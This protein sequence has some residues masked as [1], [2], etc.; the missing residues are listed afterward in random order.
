VTEMMK[1]AVA[2]ETGLAIHQVSRPEPARE[3]VLV[4]VLA[5]GMNRADLNAAKGAGIT[6]RDSWGK[7]IGMEWAG[8]VVAVGDTVTTFKPG[9][10][11]MC[12]GTGGYAEYAVA[13]FGRTISLTDSKLTIEQAAAL[14]LA[15]MTAHDAVVTNGRVRSVDT[16]LVQGASS[17]VGLASMQIAKN[18]GAR[19]VIGTSTS[20]T[21]STRLREFGADVVVDPSD[22]GWSDQ[23]LK[24]T[25]GQGANVIVDMVSGA[26]VNGSMKAAAVRGRMVNVGRLGG[27]RVDFDLDLHSLKRL[28]YIG[29]TFRTRSISEVREIVRAMHADLWETIV[30]GKIRLPIDRCFALDDAIAA[31]AHM[32]S[33][34]HFGKIVLKP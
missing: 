33:N 2:G 26:T 21:R 16:V 25:D 17:A 11:V 19:L 23:V 6:S 12:S 22:V 18:A 10:L 29:T 31:H 34:A 8:E 20:K 14:P 28:T 32:T 4:R 13:D 9:E 7:P 27:M 24:A 15:L 5:A 3:Q 30:S 1:A